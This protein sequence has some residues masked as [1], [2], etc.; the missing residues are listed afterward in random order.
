LA[1]TLYVSAGLALATAAGF[2]TV[3][4]LVL[5]RGS[6]SP[7]VALAS[8]AAFWW[9]AA[10]I[11]ADQGL[12]ALA[13]ATGQASLPLLR[14]LDQAVT[15]FYCLAA[16]SLLFYVL[17]LLT[18]KQRSLGPILLYYLAL[19]VALRYRVESALPVRVDVGDWQANVVYAEPLQ[20]AVYTLL[21]ALM[22]VPLLAAIV[23]YGA[24][25]FRVQDA[26]ARY[27]IACVTL[28]LLVWVTTEAL[29]YTTGA[30]GT[31]QGELT[32]RLVALGS[33]VFVLAGYLPPRFARAR[34]GATPAFD[35]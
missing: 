24:L 29:A 22:V 35:G 9:S 21:V 4:R 5:R 28:G 6:R 12:A 15:G 11:W 27:R 1:V 14:A 10:V 2:G 31:T 7:S 30:A 16:A 8:F 34:W 26:S 17:Y 19:F 33:T 23:A 20:G 13:G 3:G 32:R 18:G 25:A